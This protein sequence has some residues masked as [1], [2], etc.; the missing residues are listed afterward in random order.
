[1]MSWMHQPL[2]WSTFT[3]QMT[4]RQLRAR[5]KPQQ[6]KGNTMVL[7]RMTLSTKKLL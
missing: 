7:L 3:K 4:V 2:R 5:L 6:K 1:M